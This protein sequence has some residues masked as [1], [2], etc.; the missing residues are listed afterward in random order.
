MPQRHLTAYNYRSYPP[1]RGPAC[2]GGADALNFTRSTEPPMTTRSP[3]MQ[4]QVSVVIPTYNS[5]RTIARAIDSVLLQTFESLE[6]IIVDDGSADGTIRRVQQ[7][8]DG[9]IRLESQPHNRG[10]AAARNAGI[11]LARG[12]WIAFLDSDDTWRP[13]KLAHQMAALEQRTGNV[14]ASATGYYLHKESR[15]LPITLALT[16]EKFRT[17]IVF[18]CTISPGSTL[19][20]SAKVFERV[21]L[22]DEQLRRLEDWDWLMRFS[23]HLDMS[24]VSEPLADIYIRQIYGHAAEVRYA[25]IDAAIA[26]IKIKHRSRF[27]SKAQRRQFLSSLYVERA[28][29][30]HRVGKNWSAVRTVFV[31]LAIYP[32]RNFAFFRTLWRSVIA[33]ARSR[34]PSPLSMINRDRAPLRVTAERRRDGDETAKTG[35]AGTDLR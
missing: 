8:Q 35:C 30:L 4:P 15:T 2:L 19:V 33:P 31:A 9:R 12:Q 6:L 17:D 18:G 20:V 23:E 28:A 26:R 7:F 13:E 29:A 1:C 10:A 5:E 27:G 14:E 32:T 11:A 34:R 22:F 21:G 24:F 3:N 25:A 16:S